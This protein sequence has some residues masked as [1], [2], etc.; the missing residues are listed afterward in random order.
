[1]TIHD[2]TSFDRRNFLKASG[3]LA[4]GF[5]MSRLPADAMMLS[6]PKSLGKEA[7]DSWLTIAP[8]NRVTIYVG[9]VDLGTGSRTAL[10]QM[11]AAIQLI[12]A[13]GSQGTNPPRPDPRPM[14]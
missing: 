9:K 7:V 12:V 10:M 4:I 11:A 6:A 2:R 13:D 5:S 1:M 3:V 14:T 8:D